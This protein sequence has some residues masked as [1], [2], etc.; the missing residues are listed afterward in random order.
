MEPLRDYAM[1]KDVL[2]GA[3]RGSSGTSPENTIAS[4]QEA[5]DAGADLIE[6]DIRI[7]KDGEFVVYHDRKMEVSSNSKVEVIN[8][9][10]EDIRKINSEMAKD[11][12]EH[13]AI[14]FFEEVLEFIKGKIYLNLEIKSL[15]ENGVDDRVKKLLNTIEE[16]NMDDQILFASFDNNL[17]KLIHNMDI[18]YPLASIFNPYTKVYPK[19]LSKNYF[20]DA[21]ICALPELDQRI[22]DECNDLNVFIGVYS[23]DSYEDLQLSLKNNVKAIGTNF[24]ARIISYLNNSWYFVSVLN[25]GLLKSKII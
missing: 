4:F 21:F 1:G 17:L 8:L 18:S 23:V 19:E 2:I 7:T 5:I 3:H 6:M 22:I 11:D 12:S 13:F 16:H 9:T 20:F 25:M 10:K 24:P 14:P 15:G